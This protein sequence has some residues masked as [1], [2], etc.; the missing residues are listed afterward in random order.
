MSPIRL[1]FSVKDPNGVGDEQ[2]DDPHRD[3]AAEPADDDPDSQPAEPAPGDVPPDRPHGQATA[4]EP[5]GIDVVTV[6][7][8]AILPAPSSRDIPSRDI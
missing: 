1:P 2:G 4:S 7:E 6:A 3:P 5:A 8:S